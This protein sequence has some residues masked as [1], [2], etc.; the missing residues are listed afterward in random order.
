MPSFTPDFLAR[1]SEGVWSRI[2]AEPLTGFGNDTRQIQ[3]GQVFVALRTEKRDGHHYLKEAQA[4]GASAALV[5]TIDDT[6]ALPQL[7]VADTLTAFQ[8]IA[9]EHRR[10]FTGPVIG[11]TGSAGKT[12]TKNLL[13]TLL[14]GEP[15]VLWTEGNLNNHLGVPLTLTKIDPQKHRFAVVEAGISE[16]GE[17]ASLARMIEPDIAIITL[18]A[19]AHLEALGTL[20]NVA[21]EKAVLAQAAKLAVFGKKSLDYQAFRSL[22]GRTMVVEPAEVIRPAVPSTDSVYYAISRRGDRT[23]LSIACGPPPPV[24]FTLQHVSDGMA[25]NATLAICAAL[26]LGV[27]PDRLQLRLNTWMPAGMRGEIRQEKDR[28]IYLDCYNANPASMADALA[29]FYQ[30][31]PPTERRLFVLGGMEELGH[32]SAHYHRA[33]GKMLHLR[34]G[35]LC[36]VIGAE[37]EAVRQGAIEE[38]NRDDQVVVAPS[39]EAIASHVS[40]FLGSIF[41]KGSRRYALERV[42]AAEGH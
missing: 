41:I 16:S 4:A 3:P 7:Q 10:R 23:A 18:V 9:R 6:V 2:P 33:L 27:K 34:T 29:N 14:G 21:R 31:A 36:Y 25:H 32:D 19:P 26:H 30:I 1:V 39:A 15:S 24:V 28:L 13:A 11:I 8:T 42:I 38:G 35:D 12:S 5:S 22:R 17:M 20:E 40:A 37:A